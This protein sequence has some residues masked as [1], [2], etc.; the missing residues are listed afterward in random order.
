[1]IPLTARHEHEIGHPG[2]EDMLKVKQALKDNIVTLVPQ[3]TIRAAV[4][5]LRGEG[6]D[7]AL[8]G[9]DGATLGIITD[10]DIVND[11]IAMD[12]NPYV[13]TIDRIMSGPLVEV[14]ADLSVGEAGDLM[15]REGVRHL[16]VR[17]QGEVKGLFSIRNFIAAVGLPLVP[18]R[19]IMSAPVHTVTVGV[20][21]R[22]AAGEMRERRVG[23]LVVIRDNASI[24]IVT[25]TDLVHKIIGRDLNPYVTSVDQIMSAPLISIDVN[26]TVENA[27]DLMTKRRI[28][29][30]GVTEDGQV[31]GVISAR[32]LLH[33]TYYEVIGW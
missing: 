16:V 6:S 33:P 26:Q 11:I 12:L 17:E 2:R 31:V 4:E 3:T 18:T 20:T 30:L 23:S 8:V 7:Y 29:H 13:T 28:R 27:R 10:L 9:Q 14:Q 32:D 15:A 19:Q 22:S 1:M 21:A 5:V 24:G 25:E